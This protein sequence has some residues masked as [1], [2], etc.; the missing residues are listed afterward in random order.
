MPMETASCREDGHFAKMFE[1][2]DGLG[3]YK[4]AAE[5]KHEVLEGCGGDSH[6]RVCEIGKNDDHGEGG[7]R[8]KKG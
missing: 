2:A 4:N 1:I 3:G 5:A 6:G 8:S 7:L